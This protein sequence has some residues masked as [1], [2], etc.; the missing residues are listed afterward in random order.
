[1]F[2]GRFTFAAI[3]LLSGIC[4][5]A[6]VEAAS[7]F[8]RESSIPVVCVHAPKAQDSSETPWESAGLECKAFPNAEH[9]ITESGETRTRTPVSVRFLLAGHRSARPIILAFHRTH[10]VLCCHCHFLDLQLLFC[11]WQN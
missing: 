6:A 2:R 3:L 4:A 9:A 5:P 7:A 10:S 11:T 8:D 1:M